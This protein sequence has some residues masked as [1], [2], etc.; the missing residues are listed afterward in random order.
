MIYICEV[1]GKPFETIWPQAKY[2]SDECRIKVEKEREAKRERHRTRVKPSCTSDN[3][4]IIEIMREA[5][6]AGMSY[7]QYVSKLKTQNRSKKK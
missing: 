4:T 6:K 2:C 1:C 5:N 3:Q 7:G